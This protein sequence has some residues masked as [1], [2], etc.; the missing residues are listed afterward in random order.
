M[1]ERCVN[2]SSCVY[3]LT[4][5]RTCT[6]GDQQPARSANGGH[7]ADR[8]RPI[9]ARE[10]SVAARSVGVEGGD[11][12]ET[13][14]RGALDERTDHFGQPP[15]RFAAGTCFGTCLEHVWNMFG[16]C[17]MCTLF[18]LTTSSPHLGHVQEIRKLSIQ[19]AAKT[20]ECR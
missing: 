4:Q 5:P 9:A 15:K 12:A 7:L 1:C 14:R 13:R 11:A 3:D 10:R 20:E 2:D 17:L 19:L 6:G 16:T 8:D 18:S